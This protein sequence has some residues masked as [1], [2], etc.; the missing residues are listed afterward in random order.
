MSVKDCDSHKLMYH[1]KEVSEWIDGNSF[2]PIHAEIGITNKCNHK[3][4]FCTL[5][6]INHGV[7]SIDKDVMMACLKDMAEMGV[8][9]IYYA[10]EGEPTLHKN[11]SDFISYGKSMGISQSISTN[12]S[13][14]D[15]EMAEKS[16]PHLSWV[17]FSVD[18]GNADEYSSIHK[19]SAL[20]F[21]KVLK[22]IENSVKVK[23]QNNYD[24]EIGVQFILMPENID[25][26]EELAKIVKGIGVD[27]FQ[28]KPSHNHPK[29]SFTPSIYKFA[30]D[31]IEENLKKLEDSKFTVVVRTKSMERLT[32]ERNYKECH[33]F[34][35]YAIIDAKGNVVPCNVFYGNENFIYGNINKQSFKEIWL[36][37]KRKN[38]IKDVT[39]LCFKECGNYRC[40]L[41][42]INRYLERV[43]NPEKNDEFI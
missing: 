39:S 22:N 20:E 10:G 27:N 23:K 33:G 25:T 26:V 34:H 18:A 8:K 24:V 42:V 40:R 21:D 41:D 6:W 7:D 12:G 15:I 38:I 5:D 36:G 14:F 29:S 31:T 9:S 30:H 11:L 32:Q 3:C 16:L 19:V 43:K 28:V 1:P 37:N 35:F 17:R 2:P 4:V 13:R